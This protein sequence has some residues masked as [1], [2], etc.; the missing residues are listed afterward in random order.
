MHRHTLNSLGDLER[1]AAEFAA[2]TRPGDVV[3]LTGPLG[4]GKTTFVRA[5]VRALHGEDQTSSP[6]FTFWHRYAGAP[7]VDHLDLYRIEDPADLTELGLEEAFDG[8]SIVLV[9]WWRN[10]P[11]LLPPGHREIVFEGAGDEPRR[12]TVLP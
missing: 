7:P 12:V 1:F 4:A 10:A 2:T 8:R 5:L 9:E 6:T 11:A 3:G